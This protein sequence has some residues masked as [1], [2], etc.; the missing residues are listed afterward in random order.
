MSCEFENWI[1]WITDIVM[2]RYCKKNVLYIPHLGFFG[3]QVLLNEEGRFR[4]WQAITLKN[5]IV[6]MTNLWVARDFLSA[7]MPNECNSLSLPAYT[8]QYYISTV[9]WLIM[10][11]CA[12]GILTWQ[13]HMPAIWLVVQDPEL[14]SQQK[15][16]LGQSVPDPFP[17]EGVG[18]G[19]K[20]RHCD[21][22]Y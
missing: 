20:T 12:N 15:Q 22:R 19:D 7:C 5:S 14:S 9:L 3:A 17:R 11:G 16:E 1:T 2:Y 4:P 6:G 10:R 18:S 13:N 21:H 8:L